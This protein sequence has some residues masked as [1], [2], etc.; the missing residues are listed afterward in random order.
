MKASTSSSV[1]GARRRWRGWPRPSGR[2]GERAGHTGDVSRQEDAA[3]RRRHAGAFRRDPLSG[4][5]CRHWRLGRHIH[6]Y[7]VA[8]WD[9]VIAVNLR[10][11]FLMSRAVL[12]IMR[13][14]REGH[15]INISSGVG[16]RVLRGRRRLWPEQVRPER[17]GRVDPAREPGA[18]DSGQY[19]LPGHGRHRDVAGHARA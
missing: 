6:D 19:H 10:G 17:A 4:Q 2:G 7:D 15:I 9:K 18:R 14:Q 12:P 16:H 5:Q 1:A 3:R 13:Q 11:P 8:A